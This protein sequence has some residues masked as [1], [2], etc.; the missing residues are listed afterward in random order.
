MRTYTQSHTVYSAS[1]DRTAVFMYTYI[2]TYK[3]V[4]IYIDACHVWMS[5]VSH[6]SMSWWVMS[7]IDESHI[8]MRHRLIEMWLRGLKTHRY[9][10][11]VMSHVNESCHIST[12]HVTHKWVMSHL[13]QQSNGHLNEKKE[14]LPY[15]SCHTYMSHVTYSRVMSQWMS[16]N[17]S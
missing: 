15:E 10:T 8:S 16:Q 2:H 17:D 7:H 13:S 11:W 1:Y 3:Y 5:P 12:T 14:A 4:Y 6:M 9:V